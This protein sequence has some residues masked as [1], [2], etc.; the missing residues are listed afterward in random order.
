MPGG[1]LV[2]IFGEIVSK[3]PQD[4]R[5]LYMIGLRNRFKTFFILVALI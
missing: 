5:A 1:P 2:E 4:Y 3:C